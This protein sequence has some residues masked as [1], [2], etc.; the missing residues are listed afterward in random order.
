MS[1]EEGDAEDEAVLVVEAVV[2]VAGGT[3][4]EA[5]SA[6][7]MGVAGWSREPLSVSLREVRREDPGT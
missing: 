7:R 4:E 3:E 1:S 6:A 5:A 2:V